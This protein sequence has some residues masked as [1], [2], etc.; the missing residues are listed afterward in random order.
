[1]A[2]PWVLVSLKHHQQQQ[3]IN[4]K[5]QRAVYP[6]GTSRQETGGHPSCSSHRVTSVGETHSKDALAGTMENAVG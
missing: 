4:L 5:F 3:N 2:S 1:M 6:R